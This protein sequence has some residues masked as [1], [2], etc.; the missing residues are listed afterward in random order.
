MAGT[1]WTSWWS[2][3]GRW[4][5]AGSLVCMLPCCRVEVAEMVLLPSAL[6]VEHEVR[7][8][9]N[10]LLGKGDCFSLLR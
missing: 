10:V 3:Q 5:K 4:A 9:L 1:S 8:S 2:S 7:W 6:T